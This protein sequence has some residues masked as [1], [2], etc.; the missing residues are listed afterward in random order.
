MLGRRIKR[1]P[2]ACFHAQTFYYGFMDV[3]NNRRSL[4][5]LTLVASIISSM[6]TWLKECKFLQSIFKAHGLRVRMFNF[7]NI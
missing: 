1:V 3:F 7:L 6:F 5:L 2:S 4:L